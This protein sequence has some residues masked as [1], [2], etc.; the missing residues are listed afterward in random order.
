L[1]HYSVQLQDQAIP[2]PVEAEKFN[3]EGDGYT[4]FYARPAPGEKFEEVARFLTK[5]VKLVEETLCQT[6]LSKRTKAGI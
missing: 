4:V 1:T 6:T 5:N 3:C 2:M